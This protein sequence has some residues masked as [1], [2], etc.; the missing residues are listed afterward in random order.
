MSLGDK[1]YEEVDVSS[2]DLPSSGG[3][4]AAVTTSPWLLA[5]A[6]ASLIFGGLSLLCLGA[7]AAALLGVSVYLA[8]LLAT[9][10]LA[11][12]LPVASIAFGV[13]GAVLGRVARARRGALSRSGTALA[14]A[15]L[16]L[17]CGGLLLSLA[18]YGL[19]LWSFSQWPMRS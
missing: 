3:F 15:G 18:F 7:F 12:W 14:T 2:S 9:G 16:V 17:S 6:V 11:T 4:Q 5:S 13:I 1:Q 19:L 10:L 8:A